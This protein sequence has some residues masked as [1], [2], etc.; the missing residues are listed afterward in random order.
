MPDSWQAWTRCWPQTSPRSRRRC[1]CSS[2]DAWRRRH[3]RV[4]AYVN[5]R[6]ALYSLAALVCGFAAASIYLWHELAQ[7]RSVNAELRARLDAV[8][9]AM[10]HATVDSEA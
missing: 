7:E 8:P 9:A 4:A 5:M 3:D 6:R 1:A 2:K 10:P